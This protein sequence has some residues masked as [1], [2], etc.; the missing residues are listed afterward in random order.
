MKHLS[1]FAI[2]LLV[3]AAASASVVIPVG[4]SNQILIPAAGSTQGANGTFFRSDI[5][6]VNVGGT[7][8]NILL[9]WLPQAGAGTASQRNISIPSSSGIRSADFV[10]EVMIQSGLGSLLISAIIPGTT[11]LDTNARLYVTSRIWTNQLSTGGTTSQSF[12]AIPLSSI[13]NPALAFFGVSSADAPENYRVN[14][15]VV[16]V[17]PNFTQ[18]F[19]ITIP[20]STGTPVSFPVTLPPLTMQQV[21]LGNNISSTAQIQVLNTTSGSLRSN[22]WTAYVSTVENTTGDAWSELGVP[23]NTTP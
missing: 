20:V 16:N 22:F 7:A 18:T 12:P 5:A 21:S 9:Q 2:A 23:I 10:R 6:I 17:D 19:T 14:V 11:T 1:L 4:T 13:N 8:A 15:G 3:A